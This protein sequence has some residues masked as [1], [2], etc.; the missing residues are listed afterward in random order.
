MQI[1]FFKNK[2]NNN[3]NIL[4][5]DGNK[6]YSPTIV[7]ICILKWIDVIKNLDIKYHEIYNCLFTSF[8]KQISLLEKNFS[9]NN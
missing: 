1:N 7:A 6:E 5:I 8:D 3:K 4:I 2:K 9:K